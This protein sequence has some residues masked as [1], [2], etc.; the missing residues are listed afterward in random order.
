MHTG[1][2]VV[3]DQFLW[4]E[5]SLRNKTVFFKRVAI[6]FG[7]WLPILGVIQVYLLIASWFDA[8]VSEL[9]RI[10]LV[11]RLF[12][13]IPF[14]L[15]L[16]HLL[17]VCIAL[18]LVL[19][20]FFV[21]GTFVMTWLGKKLRY[22]LETY[23][24]SLL[25]FYNFFRKVVVLFAGENGDTPFLSRFERSAFVHIYGNETFVTALVT[26]GS[27]ISMGV[28]TA[29]VPAVPN[30]TAGRIYNVPVEWVHFI[31]I[32]AG[33]MVAAVAAWGVGTEKLVARYVAER[34]EGGATE[35]LC[36]FGPQC[37]LERQVRKAF[38]E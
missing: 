3:D 17:G 7:V 21:T 11:N 34:I 14:L 37:P 28:S 33:D 22:T 26:A 2:W 1:A 6:G 20:I 16:Q 31:D 25:P 27:D 38:Y 19:L 23:L 32:P 4:K 30:I 24:L 12:A 15:F 13:H 36:V 29:Y 8:P 9:L 35:T 5:E 10:P 18:G